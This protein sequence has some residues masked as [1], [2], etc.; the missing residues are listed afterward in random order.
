MKKIFKQLIVFYCTASI[1]LASSAAYASGAAYGLPLPGNLIGVSVSST[2]A[3]LKGIRVD[4]NDPFLLEFLF[5]SPNAISSEEFSRMVEYF[6][7]CLTMP[8][9]NLYVN[10]SPY[11]PER[12]CADS[13][14]LTDLGKDMLEQDYLLKQLS[15]SLTY[16]ETE[17]GKKYWDAIQGRGL[18]HQTRDNNAGMINH[19]PTNDFNKV[20]ITS[21]KAVVYENEG[22]AVIKESRLKVLADEDFVA[23]QQNGRLDTSRSLSAKRIETNGTL[24]DRS[25][26]AFKKNILPL[27]EQ[28]VNQGKNFSQLRQVYSAF[29][30]AVWF[31]KKLKDSVYKYYIDQKKVSGIDKVDKQARRDIYNLYVEAFKRG[32]YDYIHKEYNPLRHVIS[33]R[34]YFSGGVALNGQGVQF[35]SVTRRRIDD[36][37][38]GVSG[39]G[40]VQ[41]VDG[42]TGSP[43]L[44]NIVNAVVLAAGGLAAASAL[45]AE[46]EAEQAEQ[47]QPR[48][49]LSDTSSVL[50][51][52]KTTASTAATAKDSKSGA[53]L[54][55][56]ADVYSGGRVD[57][58]GVLPLGPN[59]RLVPA[60]G[61]FGG[62]SRSNGYGSLNIT[63]NSGASGPYLGVYYGSGSLGNEAT[64]RLVLHGGFTSPQFSAEAFVNRSSDTYHWSDHP[65]TSFSFTTIGGILGSPS[66]DS[67][68]YV[69]SLGNSHLQAM[70]SVYK[71]AVTGYAESNP[72]PAANHPREG[73]LVFRPLRFLDSSGELLFVYNYAAQ[74]SNSDPLASPSIDY[75]TLVV[76]GQWPLW[77]LS[78][79]P[80]EKG[81]RLIWWGSLSGRFGGVGKFGSGSDEI[82]GN[83]GIQNLIY[84]GGLAGFN[85]G[86]GN[87]N[88]TLTTWRWAVSVSPTN[89]V[90]AAGLGQPYFGLSVSTETRYDQYT[91]AD[92][93]KVFGLRYNKSTLSLP[94]PY[95]LYVDGGSYVYRY[96]PG[97]KAGFPNG[98][99]QV[100]AFGG[101]RM[102]FTAWSLPMQ[103]SITI[104]SGSAMFTLSTSSRGH[105]ASRGD[106][107]NASAPLSVTRGT[108][109]NFAKAGSAMT[110]VAGY[111]TPAVKYASGDPRSVIAPGQMQIFVEGAKASPY[112]AEIKRYLLLW[113]INLD[114]MDPQN[115][116]AADQKALTTLLRDPDLNMNPSETLN[117]FE[118][119][120]QLQRRAAADPD[121]FGA[122]VKK[123][124]NGLNLNGLEQKDFLVL[125]ARWNNNSR[126]LIFFLEGIPIWRDWDKFPVNPK[127]EKEKIEAKPAAATVP[128]A[129]AQEV[130]PTEPTVPAPAPAPAQESPAV[131][132][133]D[134]TYDPNAITPPPMTMPLLPP[135]QNPG[136][137]GFKLPR[138]VEPGELSTDSSNLEVPAKP[139]PRHTW[140]KHRSRKAPP[141]PKEKPTSDILED[142]GIAPKGKGGTI[143]RWSYDN[144]SFDPVRHELTIYGLERIAKNGQVEKRFQNMP[145]KVVIRTVAPTAGQAQEIREA[146]QLAGIFED[147]PV[148]FFAEDGQSDK[149]MIAAQLVLGGLGDGRIIPIFERPAIW[150]G[151]DPEEQAELLSHEYLE[152]QGA[153]HSGALALQYKA[154][155]GD[156]TRRIKDQFAKDRKRFGGIVFDE[157]TVTLEGKSTEPFYVSPEIAEG[158]KR[159]SSVSFKILAIYSRANGTQIAYNV[160]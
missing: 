55:V 5:D 109:E 133:P 10:L 79:G 108:Q 43:F 160:R 16:P 85:H 82:W 19:A 145:P 8:E 83:T 15:A 51:S 110:G 80:A 95:G 26:D 156:A 105:Y 137:P 131:T 114:A 48:V 116:S 68:L 63:P 111:K 104:A 57:T 124:F 101:A 159:A 125:L 141:M 22:T 88:A 81:Q 158:F 128:V 100:Q 49:E 9:E 70:A 87:G 1:L 102:S 117:L 89:F 76:A 27:L 3:L 132:V 14:A 157:K 31:K 69:A 21:A 91:N 34:R 103:A 115:L 61:Y 148:E 86:N 54:D 33:K 30:L 84:G 2:P 56:A 149:V 122:F 120:A 25:I 40:K 119:V 107:A 144:V 18:I 60:G 142:L 64:T 93:A 71:G 121:G 155:R 73:E 99:T 7:A 138:H 97:E 150:D 38:A 90:R 11:E 37:V 45:G 62:D 72:D 78:D 152:H 28:D 106:V 136:D 13:L 98:V 59:Y 47:N 23:A 129:S 113:G 135:L 36:L 130:K 139:T 50:I 96:Y 92:K 66:L 118:R 126:A 147:V 154:K 65:D 24:G 134:Q 75:N 42:R 127:S 29:I 12:I 140:G 143:G 123:N 151:A 6:L 77:T 32:A 67:Q 52:D 146:R 53:S 153:G 74:G 58:R 41:I 44:K 20:W 112:S 35:D 46:N 17:T 39:G 4:R 94:L